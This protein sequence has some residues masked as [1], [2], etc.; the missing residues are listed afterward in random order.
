MKRKIYIFAIFFLLILVFLWKLISL[1]EGFLGG[2]YYSQIFPWSYAYSESVKG[3]SLPFWFRFSHCGFPLMAEGQVGGF[4]PLNM[5]IF[6]LLPFTAAYNYIVVIHFILAG[7]F[8]YILTRE[9]GACEWGGFVASVIFCF[10]SAY[11]G[12]SCNTATLKVLC[13][14]PLEFFLIE[15]YFKNR[16]SAYMVFMGIIFGVQLL[17]G[18]VQMAFYAGILY[19]L[20]YAYRMV[21]SGGALKKDLLNIFFAGAA[22]A[23][24]FIPQYLLTRRLIAHSIRSRSDLGFALWGSFNPAGIIGGFLPQWGKFVNPS[25]DFYIGL[26][27]IFFVVVAVFSL[28]NRVDLRPVFLISVVALLISMGKYNPLYVAALK[29]TSFYSFRNPGRAVFFTITG[30]SVMAGVGYSDLWSKDDVFRGKAV[31]FFKRLVSAALIL[32][33]LSGA[34][35]RL[36][37]PVLLDAGKWYV[38]NFIYGRFYHRHGLDFYYNKVRFI[39]DFALDCTSLANPANIIS[40]S[41]IFISLFAVMSLGRRKGGGGF[42]LK[43]FFI[44]VLVADLFFYSM[45]GTGFRGNWKDFDILKPTHKKIYDH[46]RSDRSLYRILPYDLAS[47]A[48]PLWSLPNINS[49]FKIDSIAGYSPLSDQRFKAATDTLQVIDDSVGLKHPGNGSLAGKLDLIR[50]LNVKY[51][52]SPEILDHSFLE[53]VTSQDG[54]Y[55]YRLKGHLPRAF[56]SEGS[57]IKGIDRDIDVDILIYSSGRAVFEV[58]MPYTGYLFFSE[59]KAPGWEA[60]VDGSVQDILDCPVIQAVKL[61]GG[62]HRVEFRY[63][64]FRELGHK[65]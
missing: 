39:Y 54:V 24:L 5:L 30:F 6:F 23:V 9:L 36:L 15:R 18:A 60:E 41:V 10:G 1:Q 20:Y 44:F 27:G 12:C 46:L 22:G 7:V 52:L 53:Q 19:L 37:R 3:F 51:V 28:K 62:F 57:D 35:V 31:G 65:L 13:W 2:D 56:I 43:K 64:P 61:T 42:I 14:V 33:L 16:G 25:L 34:I 26:A 29:L 4:Y 48:L 38:D 17:A 40:I 59:A 21:L 63:R 47:R 55:L 49:F 8:V 11:A 45:I 50:S 32:F 58:N